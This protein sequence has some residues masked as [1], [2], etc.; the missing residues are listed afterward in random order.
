MFKIISGDD[1]ILVNEGNSYKL[2]ATVND[3]SAKLENGHKYLKAGTLLTADKPIE[4][5]NDASNVFT[6]TEDATKAQGLLL[7]D[8]NIT[9]GDTASTVLTEGV[10]NRLMMDEEV[11]KIYTDDFV[12]ALKTSLPKITVIS[13]L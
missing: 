1:G 6:P 5:T 12:K 2:T 11:Q 4:L 7:H 9:E 13:R 10:V 3:P 8:T